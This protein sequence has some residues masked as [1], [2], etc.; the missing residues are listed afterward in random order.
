MKFKELA[1]V[2][3]PPV[4]RSEPLTSG[5]IEL[6]LRKL[7]PVADKSKFYARWS[8]KKH[9][10]GPRTQTS[11]MLVFH[12]C[13]LGFNVA[14]TSE[15]IS[16]RCLL[17][18]WNAM[19]Q[20]QGMKPQPATVYRQRTDLSFYY[21][22]MWNVTVE[23]AITHFN[24]L[25]RTRPGNRPALPHKKANAQLICRSLVR[26]TFIYYHKY[27]KGFASCNCTGNCTISS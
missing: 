6:G 1:E 20:S 12:V 19:P 26:A 16:R 22:V 5:H 2:E 27:S 11:H 18:L 25:G 9:H 24:V 13:L 4:R 14:L 15:V 3:R 23:Y 7:W 10:K 8:Q 21:L 17:V